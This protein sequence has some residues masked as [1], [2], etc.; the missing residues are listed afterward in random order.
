MADEPGLPALLLRGRCVVLEPD[1]V[2]QL[3]FSLNNWHARVKPPRYAGRLQK[4]SR[5]K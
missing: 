5:Q 3:R 2:V 4:T 1:A